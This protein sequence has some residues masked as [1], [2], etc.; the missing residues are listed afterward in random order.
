MKD[1]EYTNTSAPILDIIVSGKL[2]SGI[3]NG[4]MTMIFGRQTGKSLLIAEMYKRYKE[5]EEYLRQQEIIEMEDKLKA[6][7]L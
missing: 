7:G 1:T 6:L 3:K 5:Q 2:N 4:K